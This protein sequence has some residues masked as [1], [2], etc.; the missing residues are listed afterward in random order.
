M[1]RRLLV[2]LLPLL[3][4]LITATPFASHVKMYRSSL[5]KLAIG[6]PLSN[7]MSL[8]DYAR[9]RCVAGGVREVDLNVDIAHR[10]VEYLRAWGNERMCYPQRFRP[11]Y[12]ADAFVSI[13]SDGHANKNARGYKVATY[14]V[15]G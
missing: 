13:H 12:R 15:T 9:H 1:D 3:G 4:L 6:A 5:S 10:I 14:Y 8:L 2:V 11:A 7:P